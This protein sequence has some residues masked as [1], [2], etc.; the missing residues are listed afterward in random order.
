VQPGALEC[1]KPERGKRPA[2]KE[3]T[4]KEEMGKLGG[5]WNSGNQVKARLG[6]GFPAFHIGLVPWT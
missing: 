4:A 2:D 1:G 3:E 5:I 6:S